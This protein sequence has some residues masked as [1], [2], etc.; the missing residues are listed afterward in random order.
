[1]P[2][3]RKELETLK[4]NHEKAKSPAKRATTEYSTDQG[5]QRSIYRKFQETQHL[6][7][8]LRIQ[9]DFSDVTSV[10]TTSTNSEDT[11]SRCQPPPPLKYSSSHQTE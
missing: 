5:L 3:V 9:E 7:D 4:M 10:D 6:L 2:K 1:V 11:T 8:Q